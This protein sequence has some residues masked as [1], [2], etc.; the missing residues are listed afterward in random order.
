MDFS[1]KIKEW[2]A[3]DNKLKI[4]NEHIKE[5]R[6][7]RNEVSDNILDYVETNKLNNAV[8]KISD[9]KLRF[10]DAKQY[11]PLTFKYIEDCLNKCISNEE[12]VKK[13]IKYMKSNRQQKIV[14]DIKRTYTEA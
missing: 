7:Q 13:I 12:D 11:P 9:G 2:V 14:P 3:I 4:A 1:E 8:V 6:Q 10:V 5:L